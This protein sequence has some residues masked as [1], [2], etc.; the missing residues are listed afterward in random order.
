MGISTAYYLKSHNFVHVEKC[1]LYAIM[2]TVIGIIILVLAAMGI[3][4][5]I[6]HFKICLILVCICFFVNNF[7][8]YVCL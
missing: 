2:L 7:L 8:V 1:T 3:F 5:W 6:V 4:N